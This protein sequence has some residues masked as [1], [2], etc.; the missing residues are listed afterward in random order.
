MSS[1]LKSSGVT[2]IS[3]SE[4]GSTTNESIKGMSGAVFSEINDPK[5][6]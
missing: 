5:G 1:E 6:R 2:R 3:S 4:Q